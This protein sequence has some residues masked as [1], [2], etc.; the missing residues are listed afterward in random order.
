M[1]FVRDDS[2]GRSSVGWVLGE[3]LA[4]REVVAGWL[5]QPLTRLRQLTD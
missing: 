5:N 3:D 2:K 4:G 1:E